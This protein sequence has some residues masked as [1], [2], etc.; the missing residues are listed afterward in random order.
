MTRRTLLAGA[1]AGGL[2]ACGLTTH[3]HGGSSDERPNILLAIADDWSWPHASACGDPV[4]A[5]P[6]FDRVAREGV[7]F[8]H[9]FTAAPT[10]TASRG[11]LLTGQAPHRLAEGANLHSILRPEFRSFPDLLEEA[12]V[13]RWMHGKGLEPGIRR[14]KR[15]NAQ[16]RRAG[17][18]ELR[19]VSGAGAEGPPIL[20][21]VRQPSA[22]QAV[23]AGKRS[24]GRAGPGEGE[25]A[26]VSA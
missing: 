22:S 5:T 17:L 1:A 16:S 7:L 3:S 24:E 15:A 11:S 10:C 20:L 13:L 6:A 14:E 19:A 2:A 4:I 9:A 25:S 12:G 21:L 26:S 18:Q 23:R 8:T